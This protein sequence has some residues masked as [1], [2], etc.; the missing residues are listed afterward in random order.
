MGDIDKKPHAYYIPPIFW[1]MS[2]GTYGLSGCMG[3]SGRMNRPAK[4]IAP[5]PERGYQETGRCEMQ[6]SGQSPEQAIQQQAA[7]LLSQVA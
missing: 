7:N 5:P 2:L 3:R 6:Q 1:Y 4:R